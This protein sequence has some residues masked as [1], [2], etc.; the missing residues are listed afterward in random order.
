MSIPAVTTKFDITKQD[1]RNGKRTGSPVS[2][3]CQS[4]HGFTAA[5][6]APGWSVESTN[7]LACHNSGVIDLI[8]P[9]LYDVIRFFASSSLALDTKRVLCVQHQFPIALPPEAK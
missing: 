2:V 1:M 6:S 4:P 3:E 7:F 5:E 9:C 8:C